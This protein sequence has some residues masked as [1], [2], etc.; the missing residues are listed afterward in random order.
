MYYK[1]RR[2]QGGFVWEFSN[3]GLWKEDRG[4]FAYGGDFGDFP[5]DATFALDGLCQSDHTPGRG[6]I[7]LKKV[8]EPVRMSVRDGQVS[9]QNTYDFYDLEGCELAMQVFT[10]DGRY[11][12]ALPYLL[13]L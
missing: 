11:A 10:F 9:L 3:L 6:L 13:L 5:H 4:Y 12:E 8:V 2:L 1:H 7:E